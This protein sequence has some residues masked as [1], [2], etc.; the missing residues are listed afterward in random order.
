[1][2]TNDTQLAS[3]VKDLLEDLGYSLEVYAYPE[4]EGVGINLSPLA[5][6]AEDEDALTSDDVLDIRVVV[7]LDRVNEEEGLIAV[8]DPDIDGDIFVKRQ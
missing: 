2:L 5:E 1:M 7:I 4:G 3:R 8:F 6:A